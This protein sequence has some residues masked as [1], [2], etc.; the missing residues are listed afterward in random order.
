MLTEMFTVGLAGDG[1]TEERTLFNVYVQ[2]IEESAKCQM[3]QDVEVSPGGY[4]FSGQ[5]NGQAGNSANGAMCVSI[6]DR[7][8]QL[9]SWT[10]F[11]EMPWSEVLVWE[12]NRILNVVQFHVIIRR[13]SPRGNIHLTC[14]VGEDDGPYKRFRSYI[15]MLGILRWRNVQYLPVW[16]LLFCC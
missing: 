10:F 2:C 4:A 16:F 3:A 15:I 12:R 5:G 8:L 14:C 7:R 6:R 1:E 9:R 11:L 13:Q